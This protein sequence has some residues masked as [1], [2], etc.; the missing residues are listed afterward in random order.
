MDYRIERLEYAEAL[1][2]AK[3]AAEQF[4]ASY[5]ALFDYA[6]SLVLNRQ[7]EASLAILDTLTVLPFEGARYTREV[8]RQ[9]CILSAA[10]AMKDGKYQ[11]ATRLLD[12]ARQWPE[13]LGVG[14]PYD[15][16]N[17]FEDYL[18]G[19]CAVKV[20]E[21]VRARNLLEQV[22]AYTRSHAGNMGVNRL[23]GA[24][25]EKALG[26]EQSA[27]R[28]VEQWSKDAK[29]SV[30][31]WLISVFT[32]NSAEAAASEKDLRGSSN[33]SLLGRA[34]I[35]QDFALLVEVSHSIQF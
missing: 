14:K 23:F 9:A 11:N 30:A 22:A 3:S 32:G 20:G 8:Y 10:D 2:N 4:P 12:K 5:V 16:D 18:E 35:E 15:V 6:R 27:T 13:R 25:A 19:L 33:V 21:K 31:R 1:A 26:Q 17:R 29:S 34:L 7:P 24:L 28:L